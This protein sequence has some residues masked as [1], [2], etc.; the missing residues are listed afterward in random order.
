MTTTGNDLIHIENLTRREFLASSFAAALLVACGSDDDGEEGGATGG[1]GFP[2]TVTHLMGDATIPSR[3]E[4][5]AAVADGEALDHVLAAG[6][7]PVLYG[8]VEGYD[9]K[10]MLRPWAR[11]VIEKEPEAYEAVRGEP[12]IERFAAATPDLIVA[13][14]IAEEQ[15]PVL[16][17]IAPTIVI[18]L[19]D[20]TAWPEMQRLV[21]QATGREAESEAALEETE[22]AIEAAA[23]R[24]KPYAGRTVTIGYQ[25]VGE[26]YIHGADTAIA[27]LIPRLGLEID[28]PDDVPARELGVFSLEET[29]RLEN[30]D[31]LLSPAF[32]AEDQEAFEASP[33]LQS[34]PA[35][36]EGRYVPLSVDVAAAGYL[37]STLSV[38]WVLPLLADAIIEAAEGR[39]KL[40]S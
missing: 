21:G 29:K 22:A 5:V 19:S 39:G 20:G 24:L 8:Q 10:R 17:G 3:P 12:D 16:E 32:F 35:V 38:R 28:A 27:R 36:Q 33:L 11:A 13:A 1:E 7:T 23:E 4:R 9:G 14:W 26:L 2:R 15:Y 6:I 25:F 31:I 37:E 40:L 30:A 34:L 18:K